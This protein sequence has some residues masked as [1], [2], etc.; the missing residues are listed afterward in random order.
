[1]IEI[2]GGQLATLAESKEHAEKENLRHPALWDES[3]RNHKNYGI[4]SWPAAFLI[5]ADGKVFWQGNPAR[6]QDRPDERAKFR[7]L[8]TEKLSKGK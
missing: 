8:L 2:S 5:G 6:L 3:N 1:M 4:N 7:E